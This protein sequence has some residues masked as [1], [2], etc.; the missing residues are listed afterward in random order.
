MGFVVVKPVAGLA[1]LSNVTLKIHAHIK[2]VTLC[3]H[4]VMYIEKTN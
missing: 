1:R 2:H 4:Y 3:N